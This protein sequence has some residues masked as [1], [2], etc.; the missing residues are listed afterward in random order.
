MENKNFHEFLL[1]HIRNYKSTE[2]YKNF[3]DNHESLLVP[4][5]FSIDTNDVHMY[6]Q[7]MQLCTILYLLML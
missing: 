1:V 4:Q 6:T 2:P 3:V 5:N 7:L